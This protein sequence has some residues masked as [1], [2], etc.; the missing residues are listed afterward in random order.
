MGSGVAW[1]R[2]LGG[3]QVSRK[4]K[5]QASQTAHPGNINNSMNK[6]MG[7][8]TAC[9]VVG[10]QAYSI[11]PQTTAREGSSEQGGMKRAM[12]WHRC[13]SGQQHEMGGE[14][15]CI[16][17]GFVLD[18]CNRRF[19]TYSEAEWHSFVSEHRPSRRTGGQ[20]E[21]ALNKAV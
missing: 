11:E 21:L 7:K 10:E 2:H 14:E 15:T 16:A 17:C 19:Q 13:S 9:P 5:V 18:W 8:R 4:R 20:A 12:S 1:A 6:C 3:L